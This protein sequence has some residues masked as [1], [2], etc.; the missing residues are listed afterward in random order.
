MK[1][2]NKTVQS[3][4]IHNSESVGMSRCMPTT[5]IQKQDVLYIVEHQTSQNAKETVSD[6]IQKLILRDSEKLYTRKLWGFIVPFDILFDFLLFICK[7]IGNAW[8]LSRE[9]AK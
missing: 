2:S 8:R 9:E 1:N 5:H 6:K 3:P 4:D 7:Y